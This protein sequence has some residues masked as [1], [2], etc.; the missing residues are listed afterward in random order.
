MFYECRISSHRED[1]KTSRYIV[2]IQYWIYAVINAPICNRVECNF[3][4]R[5]V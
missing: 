4:E 2:N 3:D 1:H 5:A